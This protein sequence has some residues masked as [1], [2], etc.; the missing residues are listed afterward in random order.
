[1][2]LPKKTSFGQ[3]LRGERQRLNWSQKRLADAIGT[4][5]STIN[6]WEHDKTL[7]QPFYREK[8]HHIFGTDAPDLFAFHEVLVSRGVEIEER[9]VASSLNNF[10][11]LRNIYFTGREEI[12]TR[13]REKLT[14][15]DTA[16]HSQLYAL[17]GMG[18][19]G[20]TQIAI[21]Y[22]YRY[23]DTYE[24]ILWIHADTYQSLLADFVT[25]A[26][27][28]DLPQKQDA[29]QH[30]IIAAIKYWLCTH[31][32]WLLIFDN[33]DDPKVMGE[34]I[35][36]RC[37]GHMLLTTRCQSVGLHIQNIEVTTLGRQEGVLFLLRRAR[38]IG[39]N[40]AS[41]DASEQEYTAARQVYDLLDG[42]PLA[43]EQAAA[44]IDETQIGFQDYLDLYAT[45]R[46]ALLQMCGSGNEKQYPFSVA[47]TWLLSFE[48]IESLDSSAADLLRLLAF[49]HPDSI[50]DVLLTTATFELGDT[51]KQAT[52]NPLRFNNLIGVLRRF[53]L[54][55][56]DPETRTLALHRLVQTVLIDTMSQETRYIWAERALR[57]VNR[58]FPSG[59]F[60]TWS[61][62]QLY[63][64]HV[65]ACA[66]T[67]EKWQ[68]ESLDAARLFSRAGSYLN[69][70]GHY[71]TSEKL[72]RLS[73]AINEKKLSQDHPDLARSL[74]DMGV[75]YQVLEQHAQA[76]PLL[77]KAL[78][79]RELVLPP[80]HPDLA[81]SYSCIGS[82]Y[83]T[84]GKYKQ[85]EPL[86]QKALESR[87][88]AFGLIHVDVAESLNELAM[89]STILGKHEQAEYFYRSTLTTLEQLPGS[90]HP[91]L[92][93][94]YN[95]IAKFYTEQ[96]KYAE[97]EPLFHRSLAIAEQVLGLDHP[98]VVIGLNN[99]AGLYLQQGRNI[100]AETLLLDTLK[101]A[102]QTWGT[103]HPYVSS[104]LR[105]LA[106]L[107]Y[108]QGKYKEAEELMKRTLSIRE[109]TYGSNHPSIADCLC[110][111][112]QIYIRQGRYKEA[113]TMYRRALS[114]QEEV[115]GPTHPAFKQTIKSFS[116]F[117]KDRGKEI[118]ADF[119]DVLS[120]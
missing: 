95:N 99:L 96:G 120:V 70:R 1:M 54:I 86:L 83:T 40:K 15:T 49:L 56:R 80:N 107:Y 65:Q 44:Y 26:H 77:K 46:T 27:L 93:V 115:L 53:S 119:I 16:G 81:A 118:E 11:Y 71:T 35:P 33:V 55:R 87:L 103:D 63:L 73:L 50:P 66:A 64:P 113:E 88:K 14:T 28:F 23:G 114:I 97:A 101:R 111:L 82:L 108:K 43:L 13:L 89:L 117:L 22:V 51:L 3:R 39:L 52:S 21:E 59:E 60:L 58:A 68:I 47:T 91:L 31:Q 102:E 32:H 110:Y 45:H 4:T 24:T 116:A 79:I 106:N 30:A 5:P 9:P 57:A 112:A 34:F 6:R 41:V 2:V 84:M 72:L 37:K 67:I 69:E 98:K 17:S 74:H 94:A 12:L 104:N 10:P 78:D 109:R 90:P 92:A 105:H 42:L 25:L 75:L 36:T 38:R 20:K 85:A 100:E 19:I 8:L 7:P 18:G 48:R 76:E 61:E 29:D 62:C